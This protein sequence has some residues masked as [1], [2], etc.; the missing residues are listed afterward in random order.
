MQGRSYRGEGWVVFGG[1][2]WGGGNKGAV[3]D[4]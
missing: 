1:V 4:R 2:G 3:S